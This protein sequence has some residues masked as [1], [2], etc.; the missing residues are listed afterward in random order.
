MQTATKR[1]KT[2][3]I[4]RQIRQSRQEAGTKPPSSLN[5]L[6]APPAAKPRAFMKKRE[7]KLTSAA[8]CRKIG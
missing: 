5:S 6:P 2:K 4:R 1:G 3:R 7:F 8:I